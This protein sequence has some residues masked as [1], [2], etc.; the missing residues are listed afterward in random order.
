[1]VSI[2]GERK[3]PFPSK[4]HLPDALDCRQESIIPL[5]SKYR[6]KPDAWFVGRAMMKSKLVA[7][8]ILVAISSTSQAAPSDHAISIAVTGQGQWQAWCHVA[9]DSGEEFVRA[10]DPTRATYSTGNIRRATCNF[11]NA[12]AG[13]MTIKIDG[14]KWACPFPV[15]DQGT[16]SKTVAAGGFGDFALKQKR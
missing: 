10:I 8:A 6:I 14:A 13:P 16:C 2:R 12:A 5:T 3:C 1:V 15:S 11:K 4:I 9:P 7:T